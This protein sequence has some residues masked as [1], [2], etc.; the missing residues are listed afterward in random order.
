MQS[1]HAH[2]QRARIPWN[3]AKLVGQK[4]PFK[5]KYIWAIRVR[6]QLAH[7][8]REL[9]LL[10]LALDSKLRGCD[11]VRLRVQDVCHEER[12]ANRAIVLR[13]GS[14]RGRVLS[15]R[16]GSGAR[17]ICRRDS[18]PG[19][20]MAGSGRSDSTK[21]AWHPLNAPLS[22]GLWPS[23]RQS[24]PFFAYLR[25]RP[26]RTGRSTIPLGFPNSRLS[27]AAKRLAGEG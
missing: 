24:G 12:V 20:S 10:N 23:R 9:A 14:S 17:L 25:V 1:I 19:F 16:V 2:L 4:S 7:R 5:L 22:T 6:L 8:T 13:R 27:I 11:L 18:T 21:P 26:A 3:S 15:F